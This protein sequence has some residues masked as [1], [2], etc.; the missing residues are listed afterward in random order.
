MFDE[1]DLVA[2]LIP[3]PSKIIEKL[4]VCRIEMRTLKRL[5][6]ISQD[7]HSPN[8]KSARKPSVQEG[9]HVDS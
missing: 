7:Y 3:E 5:L 6:K 2:D 1:I 8:C 9:S 4:R